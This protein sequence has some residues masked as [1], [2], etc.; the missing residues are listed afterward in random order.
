FIR[1]RTEKRARCFAGASR[2]S[3]AVTRCEVQDVYLEERILRF[4][5]ALENQRLAI[6]REITFATTPA[7]VNQLPDIREEVCFI[8]HI[9][10]RRAR[11]LEPR[12]KET[13]EG[14][15]LETNQLH[16]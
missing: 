9:C 1:V 10:F 3:V 14:G 7:F 13:S 5:L 12:Q 16:H 8:V 15:N 6:G 2:N 4:A 11:D